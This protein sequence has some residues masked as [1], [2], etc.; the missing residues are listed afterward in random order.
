M[1]T[2]RISHWLT[3]LLLLGAAT[4]VC[5]SSVTYVAIDRRDLEGFQ[6]WYT[7]RQ[8]RADAAESALD[9]LS[10]PPTLAAS[11]GII[12][13]RVPTGILPMLSEFM[14][15]RRNTCGGYFAFESA[16]D[17]T[18]FIIE[19]HAAALNAAALAVNHT[20]DNQVFVQ[21]LLAQVQESRIRSTINSLQSFNNRWYNGDGAQSSAWIRDQWR[22]LIPAARPE[23]TLSLVPC[24]NGI[25]CGR[26]QNVVLT[27]PGSDLSSEIVVLG[28]HADSI[29]S[30]QTTNASRAPG[31]DDDASG[32]AVLTE[33]IRIAMQANYRPR[34]SIHFMAYAAE[35]VGLR[36]SNAIARTYRD[37]G[38]N[39]V[40]VLQ[41]DMTNFRNPATTRDV[42][43]LTDN[44]NAS[45]VSFMRELFSVYLGT[46][47]V[48][49]GD[50]A[51]GYACSDHASWTQ[52]GFPAA[53]FFESRVGQHN[54]NIH[55][56]RDTLANSGGT[57]NHSVLFAKLAIAFMGETA[58]GNSDGA[59]SGAIDA[60]NKQR[61]SID[62]RLF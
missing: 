42:W 35:E 3:A 10:T 48:T 32:V 31:A 23:I 50:T 60:A 19:S 6:R 20:V 53:M 21:P 36:G 11:D 57:A 5:A 17:A 59:A 15:V 62:S 25:N 49:L 41:L 39:V 34:R 55:S 4:V 1:S 2:K 58:K 18:Q 40:G 46:S 44:S 16:E 33:V 14:H 47:G 26:Q 45:L 52:N 7:E 54:A 38:R 27:I 30:G 61:F 8:A 28:A 51:C 37:E 56:R 29:V 9:V 43:L 22:A 24:G 13:T 12:A